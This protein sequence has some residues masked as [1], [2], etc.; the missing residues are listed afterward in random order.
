MSFHSPCPQECFFYQGK[1]NEEIVDIFIR[2]CMDDVKLG[3]WVVSGNNYH[4]LVAAQEFINVM[5][6]KEFSLDEVVQL[7]DLLKKRYPTFKYVLDKKDVNWGRRYNHVYASLEVWD[8][9][10]FLCTI[11]LR[12]FIYG[13]YLHFHM[14]LSINVYH[15]V[16]AVG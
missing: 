9:L 16:I 5:M 1:W 6:D 7:V 8:E 15:F 2:L 14:Y 11:I 3:S 12:I 4:E 13:K 10:F